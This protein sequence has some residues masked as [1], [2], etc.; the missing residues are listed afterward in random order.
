MTIK[1][2]SGFSKRKNSTKQPTGGTSVTAFLKEGTSIENPTFTLSG[3][4]FTVDY[5]EA[6]GHYYFVKDIVSIRNN[7]I[8]IECVQDVLATYKSAIIGSSQYVIRSA[9]A[10]SPAYA[11][12]PHSAAGTSTS[13]P[14]TS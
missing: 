3:N 10:A 11:S 8:E 4:N 1:T 2:W 6:F 12:A 5:V 9:S 13:C 14:S 7:L